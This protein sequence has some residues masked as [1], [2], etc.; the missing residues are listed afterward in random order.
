[1]E[2]VIITNILNELATKDLT[3]KELVD[4]EEDARKLMKAVK[5]RLLLC[6]SD[7]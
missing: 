7:K 6:T 1:M 2:N 4:L 5:F 3:R